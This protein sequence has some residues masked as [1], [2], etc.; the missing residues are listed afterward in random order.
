MSTQLDSSIGFKKE[1]VF[2]TG[3][4]VDRFPE[5]TSETIDF[6][7]T[8]AQGAGLRVGSRAP[9]SG[10]NV[11][12]KD[13]GKGEIE[14]EVVSKGLGALFELMLGTGVSTVV[15]GALYQQLFT[16]LKN[17][18]L[19]SATIQKGIPRLDGA[20][21]VIDTYT[22]RG[23]V[24]DSWE[25]TAAN[26]D[27]V[28]LKTSWLG[29]DLVTDTAYA[30]PSYVANSELLTFVGAQ[31]IVGGSVTVPT[32]TAL[33]TGGTT[34][35]NV[36]DFSLS[37]SNGVDS[38]GFNAGGAGK[39]TRPPAVGVIDSK[40]K[41]TA[42]YTDSAFRDAVAAHSDLALVA[43]FAGLTDITAGN[44][45]TVQIVIP[46]VRFDGPMP[47]ASPSG[48]PITMSLDFTV[49]DGLVA[50]HPLYIAVRTSDTAL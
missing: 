21:N 28:K 20:L 15:A 26:S 37:W 1:T 23:A 13:G 36:R 9:R 27:I 48:E 38:G 34:V 16:P 12:V 6:D 40:G 33:A 7:R 31:L 3:V 46:N 2:G 17:D 10:R 14:L 18:Y 35:A 4:V 25:L 50:A 5:F 39:R 29:R 11:L 47:Q 43:T 45:P 22:M 42:E 19:P 41:L 49:Y 8:W 30:T 24:C 32:T 44:K